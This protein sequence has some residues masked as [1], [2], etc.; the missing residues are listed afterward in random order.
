LKLD[1]LTPKGQETRQQEL[2]AVRI[3]SQHYPDIEYAE[4]PKDEPIAWD[5]LLVKNG[6]VR[7]LAEM[8]C[9]T[10]TASQFFGSF[11][12]E[13]LITLDK[14]MDCIAQASQLGVPFVGFLYLV[15][16]KT[17]LF[18]TL[19]RPDADGITV[20]YRVE[21]SETQATVNGGKAMRM[22]AYIDMKAATV[23]RGRG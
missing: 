15:P 12:G 16:S 6:K 3:W 9:R 10:A 7:G 11:K 4:T 20:P 18:Q 13:W 23:L 1:I 21:S 22:N 14:V 5:A 2:D 8:K 17:L 19:W